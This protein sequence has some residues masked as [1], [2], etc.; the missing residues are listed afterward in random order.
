MS[1]GVAA[2]RSGAKSGKRLLSFTRWVWNSTDA[3]VDRYL[4]D[5]WQTE[6]KH[7]SFK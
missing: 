3:I 5:N 6:V 2:S 7:S 4:S 1:A